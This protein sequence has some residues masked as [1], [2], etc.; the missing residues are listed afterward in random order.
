MGFIVHNSWEFYQANLSS[1]GIY[2]KDIC[3]LES[4]GK[5]ENQDW[6]FCR[7]SEIGAAVKITLEMLGNAG[8]N[9]SLLE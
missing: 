1:N 8:E 6:I 2:W 9:T 4:K 3:S 5:L 7:N